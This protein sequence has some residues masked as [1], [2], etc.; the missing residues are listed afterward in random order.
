MEVDETYL[1]SSDEGVA[2]RGV[3]NK[4]LIVVAAPADGKGLGRIRMRVIQHPSAASIHP[5][6]KIASNPAAPSIRTPGKAM[7]GWRRRDTITR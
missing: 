6:S 3:K 2:G 7:Q 5:S 1:A 4:A